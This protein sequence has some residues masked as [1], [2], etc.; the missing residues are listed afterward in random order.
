MREV[1]KRKNLLAMTITSSRRPN[2]PDRGH[3]RRYVHSLGNH[4]SICIESQDKAGQEFS[5]F[6]DIFERDNLRTSMQVAAGNAYQRGCYSS[7]SDLDAVSISIGVGWLRI[8]LPGQTCRLSSLHQQLIDAWIYMTTNS[9]YRATVQF[10]IPNILFGG[11]WMVRGERDIY[12]NS[13]QRID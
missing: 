9:N 5:H 11:A 6:I 3:S 12:R 10:D 8:D 7:A 4:V 1:G 2:I 13:N